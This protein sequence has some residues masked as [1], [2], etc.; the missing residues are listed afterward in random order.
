[1]AEYQDIGVELSGH[2]GTIEI[3]KPPHNFFDIS[4]INQIG[5]ALEAL[6]P[7]RPMP[8]RGAGGAGQ[9]VLRRREFRRRLG[10]RQVRAASGR[11]RLAGLVAL[12][13]GG[14]AVPLAE[15]DRRRDPWRGGRR[16]ARARDGA[17]LP[18]RLSGDA[19]L[20]Q[21][22]PARLPSGLR[23]LGH[24]ARGDRQDQRRDDV[25]YQPPRHRRGGARHGP[26]RRA[27]AAGRGAR[28]RR[29][30]SPPRSPRTR[31]SRSSPPAPP[32][33]RAWRTA[34]RPRPSTSSPSRRGCARPT[35]SRK[36]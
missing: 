12:H 17:G 19:L 22:L 14:A 20:R 32:C 6:R 24:A 29:K 16:R 23:P 15:A 31:R 9:V 35:T 3:R 28:R 1:M 13:A 25:L 34:S 11:S 27:G 10:A 7:G 8:R 30:N 2:V 36:A 21:L 18:R 26:C 4:L 5:D 33:G